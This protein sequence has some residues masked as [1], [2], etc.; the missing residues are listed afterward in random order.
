M[1][2]LLR[3]FEGISE[4]GL[5]DSIEFLVK[6]TS[7]K[8]N[9]LLKLIEKSEDLSQLKKALSLIIIEVMESFYRCKNIDNKQ[10]L[11]LSEIRD[12]LHEKGIIDLMEDKNGGKE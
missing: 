8:Q 6:E 7:A 11:I 10:T 3:D 1:K 12:K 5:D 2:Y 4:E 9:I